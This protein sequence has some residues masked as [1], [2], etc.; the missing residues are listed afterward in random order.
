MSLVVCLCGARVEAGDADALV[1]A[2]LAHTNSAHPQIKASERRW[3]EVADAIRRTGGWDGQRVPLDKDVEIL[4]LRPDLKDDYLA[5]FDGDALSDNPV[6]ASCYCLAYHLNA[7]PEE[8]MERTREQNRAAKASLIERGEATGVLAC[9]GGRVIGWCHAAPRTA[10]GL[11]DR[12]PEFAS[13]DPARTG[14][15]VCYVIAPQYRGQGL[16][17]RLL[18]GACDM[19]RERGLL[20]V[21]AYPPRS[22][23]GESGSY[24]GRM[25][26]YVAAG[27]EHV[28]DAGPYA[29][30]RRAL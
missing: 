13:D 27:F 9:A 29:V 28:R 22:P 19:L 24:R 7:P 5:F 10:L 25:S 6:W 18:D 2:Y 3:A 14:A 4:P 12:T 15:I 20:C 23:R 21:D 17:R 11:L 1:E 26:M 8:F 16:A 30:M